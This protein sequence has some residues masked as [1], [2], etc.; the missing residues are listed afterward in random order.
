LEPR[1]APAADFRTLPILPIADPTVLNTTRAIAAL[2]HALGRRTDAFMKV[3]DSNTETGLMRVFTAPYLAPLGDPAYN[4]TLAGLTAIAPNLIDTLNTFRSPVDAEGFNSFDHDSSAAFPGWTL[5][6]VL[7]N[8]S[9]EITSTNAGI[10]LVMIGTNDLAVYANPGLYRA[11]L[12]QLVQTLMSVGVVPVLSTVPDHADNPVFLPL[13]FQYNQVIADVGEQFRVPVWNLYDHLAALP[14]EGLD[15][16]GVHL[17][18]SPNGSGSF[19]PEDLLYG[20]N[21]RNLD[22][23][24]ILDWFRKEV[25]A[26]APVDP[27]PVQAPPPAPIVP[28][29]LTTSPPPVV[30]RDAGQVTTISGSQPSTGGQA[31]RFLALAPDLTGGA[32]AAVADVN[33]GGLTEVIAA[34]SAG[35]PVVRVFDGKGGSPLTSFVAFN[36]GIRSG[37]AV[38]AGD[39]ADNDNGRDFASA[40]RFLTDDMEFRDGGSLLAGDFAGVGPASVASSV[41]PTR[42]FFAFDGPDRDGVSVAAGN[43]TGGGTTELVAAP[44]GGTPEMRVFDLVGGLLREFTTDPASA[45]GV[46]LAAVVLAGEKSKPRLQVANASGDATAIRAYDG[47][48]TDPDVVFA[49]PG[50]AYGQ[51]VG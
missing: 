32:R 25:L 3:G 37:F 24:M 41:P 4:P 34:P 9:G 21:A 49:D 48:A 45:S 51:Y 13:V 6:Y 27:P 28:M 18:Y 44:A 42:V 39:L 19:L 22:A 23:L 12:T 15:P 43:L 8:L 46:G 29:T 2:G 31:S 11:M 33:G 16:G 36:T 50:R 47:L 26:P 38:A 20:Q 1:D 7:P 40:S 17:N 30:G 35:G 14:H 10:A 5:P